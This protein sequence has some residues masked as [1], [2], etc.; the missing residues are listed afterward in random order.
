MLTLYPAGSPEEIKPATNRLIT[1]WALPL[2]P[3]LRSGAWRT[4]GEF[5]IFTIS[6]EPPGIR[7]PGF[8]SFHGL[9]IIYVFGNLDKV[10]MQGVDVGTGGFP[11]YDTKLDQLR[12]DGRPQRPGS[13]GMAPVPERES[14]LP[15]IWEDITARSD[16]FASAYDL[17]LKV[18]D[19][20]P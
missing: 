6:S 4:Q 1:E 8:G 16:F 20:V 11:I 15:R 13:C 17:V 5:P 2:P 19:Y 14:L 9:E 12:P 3:S 18:S 7:A 10:E